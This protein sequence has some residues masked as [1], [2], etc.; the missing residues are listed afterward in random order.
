ML[1][2][3]GPCVG[4]GIRYST[5]N[6]DA[7]SNIIRVSSAAQQ[8]RINLKMHYKVLIKREGYVFPQE[9]S[10]STCILHTGNKQAY[11]TSILIV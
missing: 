11:Y 1:F 8:T 9:I 5:G 10:L 3:R 2:L 4:I 6:D 7:P